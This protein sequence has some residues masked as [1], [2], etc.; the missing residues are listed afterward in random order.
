M[1]NELPVAQQILHQHFTFL[2]PVLPSRLIF[3]ISTQSARLR[4]AVIDFH[5]YAHYRAGI[6]LF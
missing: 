1:F 4:K 5:Q 6:W 2:I 3:E